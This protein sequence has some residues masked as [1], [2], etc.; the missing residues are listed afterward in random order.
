MPVYM[1]NTAA[2]TIDGPAKAKIAADITRI[3]CDVTGALPAF[4]N[5]FFFEAAPHLPLGDKLVTVYGGIRA[6]RSDAQKAQI[7]DKIRHSIGQHAGLALEGIVVDIRD[8]PA[9]W[10]MEGGAV[11]PE[12]GEEAAWLAANAARAGDAHSRTD[13]P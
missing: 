5:A 1:L 3:H 7:T 4:V 8:T 9:S 10:T 11:M 13:G 12:P 6:G 2:G